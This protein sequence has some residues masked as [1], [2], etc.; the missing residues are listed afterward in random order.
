MMK[1]LFIT[2][3]LNFKVWRIRV[4]GLILNFYPS[5]EVVNDV[6]KGAELRI[7]FE[8]SLSMLPKGNSNIPAFYSIIGN[9]S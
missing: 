4:V 3:I 1:F 7:C 8:T 2:N 5:A 6:G 9:F